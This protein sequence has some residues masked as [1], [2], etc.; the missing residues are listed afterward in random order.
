MPAAS[1][2][3]AEGLS[4]EYCTTADAS[5]QLSAWRELYTVP[6]SRTARSALLLVALRGRCSTPGTLYSARE[7]TWLGL[8]LGLRLGSGLLG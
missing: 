4:E 7:A 5:S 2:A 8:G 3:T 1:T 6:S